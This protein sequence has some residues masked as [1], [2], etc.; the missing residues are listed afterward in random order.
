MKD[1]SL[2]KW[3]TK[4]DPNNYKRPIKL[5]E[6]L[7]NF[8]GEKKILRKGSKINFAIA[9]K[10]HDEGLKNILVSSDYF[11]GKYIKKDLVDPNNNEIFLSFHRETKL[12]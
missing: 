8:S 7:V 2:N 10:I 4:F 9:R 5:K 1:S 6:D 12:P 3:K 11:I